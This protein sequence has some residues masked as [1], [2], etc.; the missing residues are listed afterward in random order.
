MSHHYGILSRANRNYF[1]MNYTPFQNILIKHDNEQRETPQG[2]RLIG[3]NE[4]DIIP[5]QI[6]GNAFHRINGRVEANP[7]EN[8]IS[9][10]YTTSKPSDVQFD[11]FQNIITRINRTRNII[12]HSKQKGAHVFFDINCLFNDLRTGTRSKER[13][14]TSF[15]AEVMEPIYIKE[16]INDNIQFGLLLRYQHFIFN[17]IDESESFELY[18]LI[19][20]GLLKKGDTVAIL[21]A[22]LMRIKHKSRKGD[23][24]PYFIF[25]PGSYILFNFTSDEIKTSMRRITKMVNKQYDYALIY[26]SPDYFRCF[27]DIHG[28]CCYFKRHENEKDD[29]A[30]LRCRLVMNGNIFNKT[31]D[32]NVHFESICFKC[33]TNVDSL[34]NPC[35]AHDDLH[36]D[37][38]G[39]WICQH[40]QSEEFKVDYYHKGLLNMNKFISSY[41][42]N[43]EQANRNIRE[44]RN[45]MHTKQM[46]QQFKI[47]LANNPDKYNIQIAVKCDK[48]KVVTFRYLSVYIPNDPL[49][50]YNNNNNNTDIQ[51]VTDE[52]P[53]VNCQC[54]T[55]VPF[56]YGQES[57]DGDI[58]MD[59]KDT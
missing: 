13:T 35:T 10:E 37:I 43:Y 5:D 8:G 28:M 23:Y 53:T 55:H 44:E 18:R 2:I 56:Y 19:R 17:I 3:T 29:S 38:T 26:A 6:P 47:T 50:D 42:N 9:I 52:A 4:L 51:Q 32:C 21:E 54:I 57:Q 14:N 45:F 39:H 48:R 15:I 24:I 1:V 41:H 33:K 11:Y 7:T 25:G 40:R 20:D 34:H 22:T 27:S 36:Y 49:K 16:P 30:L 58:K 46:I 31:E 59:D 12:Y